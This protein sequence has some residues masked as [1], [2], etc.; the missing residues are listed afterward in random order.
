[1]S[2]L[3][4]TITVSAPAKIIL[5]GEHAVVYHQPALAVPLSAIRVTVTRTP[6]AA[7]IF[8]A[9]SWTRE[10]PA[11]I[12]EETLTDPVLKMAQATAKHLGITVP[13]ARYEIAST[14]PPASGLG[15]GAAVSAAIGRAV[16]GGHV[17]P[18][19]VLNALVY[20]IE[21]IHHGTPSGIDNTVIVY[22]Q[23]V[24]FVR[25][26]EPALFDVGQPI[27]LL[28]ADT[29][30]SA[31]TK[32]SVGDV[33]ALVESQPE[34]ALS[35]I[36]A[37]GDIVASA[38]EALASGNISQLGELMHQNH[39]LLRDLTVSSPEL[40]ALVNAATQAGALGAKLSGGGRGGNMIALVTPE[41][42]A[43]VSAA[44]TAA[45]AVRVIETTLE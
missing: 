27:H 6:A 38:R 43:A 28:V 3:T 7:P 36:H 25:G 16:A 39:A 40:E 37:I 12:S 4:D 21:R 30:R 29:G 18:A 11:D 19:S 32:E 5:F 10:F 8:C 34:F 15:S 20:D 1:M 41:A 35:R 23:P 44:L 17:L 42:R 45:G 22:E 9:G 13:A 26:S 33:R 14:I 24:F 31:L 2:S